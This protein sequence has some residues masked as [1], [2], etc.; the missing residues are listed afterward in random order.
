MPPT[1]D[2]QQ[3]HVIVHGRVQGVSFRYYTVQNARELM[4]SGWVKNLPQ[5]RVEVLAEGSRPQLEKLLTFLHQ[6]PPAAQVSH[7]DI[8][9][10][11][12]TNQY[13]EFEQ[14]Y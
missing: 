4:L 6:G 3:L 14:R 7:L 9:W 8:T 12:A 11:D 10:H 1:A 2:Y 5:N 13:S